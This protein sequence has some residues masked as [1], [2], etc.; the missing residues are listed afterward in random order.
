MRPAVH[1]RLH[2]FEGVE[3]HVRGCARRGI[4]TA[5]AL[6]QQTELVDLPNAEVVKA[7]PDVLVLTKGL[8]ADLLAV[9]HSAEE[10]RHGLPADD[11]DGAVQTELA[12]VKVHAS[13]G[14]VAGQV[15][16]VAPAGFGWSARPS[17]LLGH[18]QCLFAAPPLGL[19][20]VHVF[21]APLLHAVRKR[22]LAALRSHGVV[23]LV[24]DARHGLA[25]EH[26]PQALWEED[27]V[28]IHLHCPV[29]VLVPPEQ[30]DTVPDPDEDVGVER[31]VPLAALA[32][33]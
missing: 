19:Q 23:R 14:H 25:H 6:A 8:S 31:R 33:F 26:R 20:G 29:M 13:G 7:P 5:R 2:F 3:C 24:G 9:R 28:R 30:G 32:H 27:R 10:R 4:L 18:C 17:R 15:A 16:A 22:A 12:V 1:V 21:C 11:L